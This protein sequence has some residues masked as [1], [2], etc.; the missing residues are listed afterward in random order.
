VQVGETLPA[1]V[2]EADEFFLATRAFC[3]KFEGFFH[4]SRVDAAADRRMQFA[5]PDAQ[6][7]HGAELVLHPF[8]DFGHHGFDELP[9]LVHFQAADLVNGFVVDGRLHAVG[10]GGF[11]DARADIEVDDIFGAEQFFGFVHAVVGVKTHSFKSNPG[12]NTG[13]Y[14]LLHCSA[15]LKV[16]EVE[17]RNIPRSTAIAT[18]NA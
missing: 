9:G 15:D 13:K 16:G 14:T 12:H 6:G 8:D 10:R 1:I 7:F 5:H 17:G 11:C 18:I 4:K 3:H 2:A